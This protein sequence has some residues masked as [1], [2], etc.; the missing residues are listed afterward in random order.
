MRHSIII[1][2]LALAACDPH[3]SD[4]VDEP[5][6]DFGP[7]FELSP[8]TI[9]DQE[10]GLDFPRAFHSGRYGMS[11]NGRLESR[12]SGVAGGRKDG[13]GGVVEHFDLFDKDNQHIVREPT[14]G[15]FITDV[16]ACEVGSDLSG[17]VA[18]RLL[19]RGDDPQ[20]IGGCIPHPWVN[21]WNDQNLE[22]AY[23]GREWLNVVVF[24]VPEDEIDPQGK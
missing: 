16:W 19:E 14:E 7:V 1:I 18:V 21:E 12:G 20:N 15:S 23:Y 8:E 13:L 6:D 3:I 4:T 10:V 5:V 11:F 24:E 22:L 2:A 17:P 9:D